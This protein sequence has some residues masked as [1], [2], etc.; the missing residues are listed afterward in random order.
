VERAVELG[1]AGLTFTDHFDTHP[2]EWP[3]CQYNYDVLAELV[4]DLRRQFGDRVFIGHGIEVCYQPDQME[5]ILDY[6]EGHR[7]DV[8]LLSV[9][10]FGARALHVRE[11]WQ[12]LDAAAGTRAY[13]LAVLDAVRFAGTLR[14][15]SR[16]FD[17]L[18][19]LD[20]VKRYTQRYF[21][22]FDIRSHRGLV[23]EILAACLEADLVPEVNLST[24][25]QSLPEPSPADWVVRRYADLG[26]TAMSLGS[27]SHTPRDV[28]SGIPEAAAMLR[29]HGIDHLAIF[30]DRQRHDE[31][32]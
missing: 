5:R 10:W 11:H 29:N 6:L 1:L 3:L 32:L 4:A 26:G 16:V 14:G 30:R 18:G 2:T 27:D 23:D 31:P 20:L 9:H 7:F 28:G 25:R 17:V 19:H 22:T 13:L 8:V 21:H 24:L 12:D 15:E